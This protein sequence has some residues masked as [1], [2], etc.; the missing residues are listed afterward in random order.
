MGR[1]KRALAKRFLGTLFFFVMLA[2]ATV[3]GRYTSAYPTLLIINQSLEPVRLYDGSMLL[4]NVY[5]GERRCIKLRRQTDV[6]FFLKQWSANEL[7]PTI[8]P[9]TSP[10][11]EIT[12]RNR[13]VFDV[14]SLQPA[15]ACK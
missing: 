13:L 1:D 10:G 2:C 7:A 8:N 9:V 3:V 5:P 11:W 14:L 4:A 6:T 15:E 12:V